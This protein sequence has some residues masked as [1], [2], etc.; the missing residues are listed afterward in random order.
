MSLGTGAFAEKNYEDEEI[1]SYKYGV[2]N[3]NEPELRNL[4]Y[5]A[6][7]TIIIKKEWIA[8]NNFAKR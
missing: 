2:Y 5:I 4:A 3:L 1:V 7:G 6:D 8:W